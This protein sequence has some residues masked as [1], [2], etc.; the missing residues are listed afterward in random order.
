VEVDFA[1]EVL[2]DPTRHPEVLAWIRAADPNRIASVGSEGDLEA[3]PG[4]TAAA[5]G[6][7]PSVVFFYPRLDSYSGPGVTP[8]IDRLE[9]KLDAAAT[10][11]AGG[12]WFFHGAWREVVPV[13]WFVGGEGDGAD[14]GEAWI[15]LW[16]LE[17]W[18]EGAAD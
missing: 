1:H 18:S 15:F 13:R 11:H 16:T 9:A 17:I 10:A 7:R 14:P 8:R 5:G 3:A 4:R 6:S 12:L 2:A